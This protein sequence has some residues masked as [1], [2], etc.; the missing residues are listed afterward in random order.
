MGS[1]CGGAE[2]RYRQVSPTYWMVVAFVARH[3]SQKTLVENFLPREK[4]APAVR[5]VQN[6]RTLAEE[7]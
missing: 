1:I 2:R 6:P 7:W 5:E 3:S 4:V